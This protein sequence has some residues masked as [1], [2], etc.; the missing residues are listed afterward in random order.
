MLQLV[1]NISVL[2]RPAMP[3]HVGQQ[4]DVFIKRDEPAAPVVSAVSPTNHVN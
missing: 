4:V 2:E 1:L 3:V